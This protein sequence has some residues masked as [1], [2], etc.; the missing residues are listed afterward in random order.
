MTDVKYIPN[1]RLVNL[2]GKRFS[3]WLVVEYKGTRRKTHIWLCKCD[4][5]KEKL[6][7]N[8]SLRRGDSKSC[9]CNI[10]YFNRKNKTTHGMRYTT[11]YRT[12]TALKQRCLSP[13]N[14]N[15]DN[16]G[17]RGIAVCERWLK[18]ENFFEDMGNKPSPKH[19]ID[20]IDNNGNY[21]PS[22]CKWS[23]PKEQCRNRKNSIFVVYNEESICLATLAE[24]LKINYGNL[25][26]REK[27]KKRRNIQKSIKSLAFLK[28]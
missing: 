19:S 1:T 11:E 21:E 4:C 16:Y 2:I 3:F 26:K 28:E 6:V 24:L 25:W 14:L 17:G 9:G 12:W 5:G 20:R 13:K 15:Y 18:F 27:T 10:A 7:E 8:Q 22:N 23:T